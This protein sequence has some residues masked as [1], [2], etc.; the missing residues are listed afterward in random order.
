MGMYV[1]VGP[2]GQVR[3]VGG[4]VRG[5]W[6]CARW[7]GVFGS[8]GEVMFQTETQQMSVMYVVDI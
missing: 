6:T 3:R 5:V 2:V 8:G 4:C 1:M 7:L